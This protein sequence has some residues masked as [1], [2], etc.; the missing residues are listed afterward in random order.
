MT[1]PV[2]P[3]TGAPMH[4]GVRPMTL[5]YK[6]ASTDVRYAGLVLRCVRREHP[7]RRG[8]EGVRPRP[9]SPQGGDRRLALPEEIK[10]IRDEAGPN[11]GGRR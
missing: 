8:H 2:C 11:P 4:R 6:G 3:K 5:N 10:R 1:N 9:Q 7:Y